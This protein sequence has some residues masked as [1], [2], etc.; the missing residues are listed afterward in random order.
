MGE[1][2]VM[3]QSFFGSF[4]PRTPYIHLMHILFQGSLAF[5]TY[6]SVS[7]RMGGRSM[8]YKHLLF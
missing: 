4:S 1:V 3:F 8:F 5:M 7:S 2:L 6:A